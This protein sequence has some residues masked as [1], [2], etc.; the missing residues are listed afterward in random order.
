[1]TVPEVFAQ[2][3]NSSA[4]EDAEDLAL[5]VVEFGWR[6]TAVFED[7]GTEKLVDAGQ[8]K[9]SKTGT[10]DKHCSNSL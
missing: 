5:V 3:L 2:L 9:M 8:R 6:V 4:R 7:V 1:M 10:V